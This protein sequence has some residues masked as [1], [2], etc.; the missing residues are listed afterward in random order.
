V[1]PVQQEVLA[2][3][4][5]RYV[6]KGV[7]NLKDKVV[8]LLL[9]ELDNRVTLSDYCITLINLILPVDNGLVSLCDNL[10]FFRDQCLKLFYLSDL[11]S[12]ISV[13]TLSYT[14]QQTHTAAQQDLIMVLGIHELDDTT[15][16]LFS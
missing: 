14:S 11:S 8:D 5:V 6:S 9:E 4:E 15:E 3:V 10:L 2:A 7:V 16:C 1:L 13:L 12:S